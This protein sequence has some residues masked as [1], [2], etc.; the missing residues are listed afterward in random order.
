M[1]VFH[2]E[3]L[4]MSDTLDKMN[5]LLG[6]KHRLSAKIL[7]VQNERPKGFNARIPLPGQRIKARCTD[8][9]QLTFALSS[10]FPFLAASSPALAVV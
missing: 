6:P 8:D 3:M 2:I 9:H 7:Y 1:D 4:M 5:K 10:H